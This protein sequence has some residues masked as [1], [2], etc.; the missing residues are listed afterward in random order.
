[1]RG[2]LG[3]DVVTA[4]SFTVPGQPIPKGRPR[5]F[6]GRAITPPRTHVYERS[7]QLCALAELGRLKRARRVWPL[8]AEYVV[9]C[10]F[11]M[12]DA[13]RV[14]VDNLL[15]SVLDA[16]NGVLWSDDSRVCGA[17]VARKIDRERP[18]LEVVVDV[19]EATDAGRGR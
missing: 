1:M 3:G 2:V 8:D 5:V 16:G 6:R 7:V 17:T 10:A 15:K 9:A 11:Y 13:R 4:L 18:R 12:Q 14:D 19:I